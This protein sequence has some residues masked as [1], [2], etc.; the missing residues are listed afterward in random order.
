MDLEK[1]DPTAADLKS[2]VSTTKSITASDLEDPKQIAI[3][4]ENR[5]QLKNARV[6]IQ[7]T[8]KSLREDALKFQRAVIEKEKEL[9]SIIEPEENRLKDIE[10]EA[11]VISDRKKRLELIPERR[12]RLEAVGDGIIVSDDELLSMDGPAFE[13]YFNK[14]RADKL[15]ADQAAL[16]EREREVR[17]A[18]E[19]ARREKELH[20][21]KERARLEER[22]RIEEEEK[23]KEA[24]KI[25]EEKAAAARAEAEEKKLQAEKKYQQFLSENGYS[26]ETADDYHIIK[27]A[28]SVTLYKR[29]ATYK[30]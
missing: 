2:L 12:A 17:A 30:I 24:T 20:E 8:G 26:T 16:A 3:V 6:Q 19:A 27:T 22:S 10:D 1:F 23:R 14:R 29:L 25:A 28:D 5:I 18:E 21:A 11:K 15:E 7:K 13:G 9:I 4:R